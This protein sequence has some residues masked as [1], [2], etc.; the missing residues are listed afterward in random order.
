MLQGAGLSFLFG[1]VLGDFVGGGAVVFATR[2]VLRSSYSREVETRADLYGADLMARTGGDPRALGTILTRVAGANHP[3]MKILLDHP[4]TE[5]R[6]AAINAATAPKTGTGADR[7]RRMG[8]AQ[9]HLR[10]KPKLS[11]ARRRISEDPTSRLAMWA[12]RLAL[13]ALAVALLAIV[14]V[15]S[16]FVEP[17][18]GLVTF[19][20]ALVIAALAMLLAFGAFIVIWNDG[21]K[22]LGHALFA[23]AVGVALI[24]YP[25]YLGARS[26][27]LAGAQR[28]HHRHRRSAALRGDRAP[29]PARGQSGRLSGR[30]R[31]RA[32]ADGP[33]RT[34]SRCSSPSRRRR[35]T[36]RRSTSSPSASGS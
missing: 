20:G 34:S 17:V 7:A 21:L 13:F 11:M 27:R 30:A 18:P 23:V 12:R 15:Q 29:A 35:P 10:R 31:R 26:Y 24:A 6:V 36:R 22:G 1:M 25:A 4:D 19:G 3:G 16:G 14:V 33:I 2:A 9:A 28:H 32:A 5:Q 8:R